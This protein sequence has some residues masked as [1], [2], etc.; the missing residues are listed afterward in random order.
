MLLG[1]FL[2]SFA[3]LIGLLFVLPLSLEIKYT[4]G[5]NDDSFYL[6]LWC[7]RLLPIPLSKLVRFINNDSEQ[8]TYTNQD[9]ILDSFN[10]L[11]YRKLIELTK[12][13]ID[14]SDSVEKFDMN[15]TYSTGD[16]ALTGVAAGILWSGIGGITGISTHKDI[17]INAPKIQIRPSFGQA[18]FAIRLHCIF[19]IRL[20]H[21][22]IE[23]LGILL[24]KGGR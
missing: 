5:T 10:I 15:M 12:M 18:M 16:A 21:I 6:V 8:S 7:W 2:L 17:W 4:Q 20:G 24:G 3:L 13:L 23:T 14:R 1:L 19:Q 11:G 22:I 9:M